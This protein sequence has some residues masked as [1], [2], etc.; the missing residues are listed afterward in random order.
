[1]FLRDYPELWAGDPAAGP[2]DY[3]PWIL[4]VSNPFTR[5]EDRERLAEGL[6]RAGLPA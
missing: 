5:D 2:A 6:R 3:I 4:N 1:L